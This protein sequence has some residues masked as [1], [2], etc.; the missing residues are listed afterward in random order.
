MSFDLHVSVVFF[1]LQKEKDDKWKRSNEPVSERKL[2]PIIFE[3]VKMVR[4]KGMV[5]DQL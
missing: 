1:S 5:V 3:K 2:E 4:P